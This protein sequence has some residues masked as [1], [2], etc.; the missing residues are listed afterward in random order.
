M[1]FDNGASCWVL[2]A[3]LSISAWIKMLQKKWLRNKKLRFIRR[4]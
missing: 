3:S 2:L 1:R 4:L